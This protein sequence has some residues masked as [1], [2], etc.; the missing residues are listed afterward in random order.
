MSSGHFPLR[1]AL[2]HAFE[3][4]FFLAAAFKKLILEYL[5][6]GGFI[7]SRLLFSVI[8]KKSGGIIQFE[9]KKNKFE[10]CPGTKFWGFL[11]S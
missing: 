10:I 2:P 6:S 11:T 9:R 5:Y 8:F 3:W 7:Y 4:N 1:I